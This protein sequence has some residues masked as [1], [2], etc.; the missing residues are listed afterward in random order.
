MKLLLVTSC[1]ALTFA[2]SLKG[3]NKMPIIKANSISV[4]IKV[5]DRLI[6]NAW[7]IVPEEKLDV[8]KTS[9][10]E[11]TF[12]TDIDSISYAI[13][14][15]KEY[16]FIILLNGKDSARTQIKYVPSRLEILKGAEAYNYSDNRY[17]PK[18]AYQSAYNPQLVKLR[19]E[20]KLD[21]IAGEGSQL[22]QIFNLMHWV[23]NLI[24]HDGSSEN[25]TLKNAIDL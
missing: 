5:D 16:D 19:Q 24:K 3:Q 21:S 12:Y 14:P 17:I 13:E 11:V 4:D 6:K 7:S 8:Y 25:P 23:H 9:A 20:L 2:Q 18:F 15:N 1:I 10:K 22:S